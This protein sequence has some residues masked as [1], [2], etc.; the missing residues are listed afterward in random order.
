[1]SRPLEDFH[2]EQPIKP[3]GLKGES[4]DIFRRYAHQ[5]GLSI[6]E[7]D[8]IAQRL[9]VDVAIA[10]GESNLPTGKGTFIIHPRDMDLLPIQSSTAKLGNGLLKAPVG[11]GRDLKDIAKRNGEFHDVKHH[12]P[13]LQDLSLS[14]Q[15]D[16]YS[17]HPF[18]LQAA[19]IDSNGQTLGYVM[20][21][22]LL[23]GEMAAIRAQ[24]LGSKNRSIKRVADY[25]NGI[26]LSDI[27]TAREAGIL[28][29]DSVV[30][31]SMTLPGP[32][33]YGRTLKESLDINSVTGH[34][35][36]S[37]YA[38]QTLIE[39][40]HRLGYNLASNSVGLM[41][42]GIMGAS[43]AREIFNTKSANGLVIYDKNPDKATALASEIN[44]IYGVPTRVVG[45][46]K[47]LIASTTPIVTA[48]NN[49][50]PSYHLEPDA[51]GIFHNFAVED[52]Q[53]P[54]F[55]GDS[56]APLF[57][58]VST[59]PTGIS[60]VEIISGQA[61]NNIYGYGQEGLL[62]S[63]E[64]IAGFTCESQLLTAL[65]SRGSVPFNNG[66]ANPD[67]INNWT[68]SARQVGVGLPKDLQFRGYR[69]DTDQI[70]FSP[71]SSDL[72]VSP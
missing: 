47:E 45:S 30:G 27:Y 35:L 3:R 46:Y 50:A 18:S 57:G 40:S 51:N 48:T 67:S 25:V 42:A 36:T 60:R 31:L 23:L 24:S 19:Y 26:L 22:G 71:Q 8:Q 6:Q 68:Q 7:I 65:I 52:S 32:T 29:P 38:N 58:V 69:V 41:G 62:S 10:R 9:A 11:P 61:S 39:A 5:R 21:S 66:P 15:L 2:Y 17:H 59:L 54:A 55:Y 28:S 12:F 44:Q 4:I 63:N 43:I 16:V 13:G 20:G 14:E 34:E 70:R 49:L 56:Q 72:Q 53:P 37:Y 33:D 1:M 64:A